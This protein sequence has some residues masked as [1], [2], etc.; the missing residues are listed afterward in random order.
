MD[1]VG[2]VC[3]RVCI[4]VLGGAQQHV[5][6]GMVQRVERLG[7]LVMGLGLETAAKRSPTMD[8]HFCCTGFA[9]VRLGT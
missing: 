9:S 5:L 3:G 2:V 1:G 8:G 6:I 7:F 4:G